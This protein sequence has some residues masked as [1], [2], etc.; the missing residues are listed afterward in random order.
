MQGIV[1]GEGL[2]LRNHLSMAQQLL[3]GGEEQRRAGHELTRDLARLQQ[4]FALGH[5]MIRKTPVL[6]LAGIHPASRHEELDRHMIGDPAP[7]LDGAGVRQ[8]CDIDL[9]QRKACVFLHDD[10]VGA[11]HDLEAT[12]AGDAVDGG[13]DGFVE[14]A[15]DS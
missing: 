10:D 13:D 14:I 2:M 7:Q 3:D 1:Q 15:R 5:D 4:R 6:G 11:E 9:R 8:H 12:A